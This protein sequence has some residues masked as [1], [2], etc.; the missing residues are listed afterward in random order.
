[1]REPYR[2]FAPVAAVPASD[3][4]FIEV[5]NHSVFYLDFMPVQ[6][7]NDVLIGESEKESPAGDIF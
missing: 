7:G 6:S 2:V 3:F 1:M 5:V 4:P